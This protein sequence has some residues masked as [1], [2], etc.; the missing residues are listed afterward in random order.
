MLHPN[1][2]KH[3]VA[4]RPFKKKLGSFYISR[5]A[6]SVD[7]GEYG[8]KLTSSI[9]ITARQIESCRVAIMRRIKQYKGA[10]WYNRIFPDTPITQKATGVRM[11]K[12]KGGVDRYEVFAK[13]GTI[14]FE[15][16]G[17]PKDVAESAFEAAKAKLP[18]E[19]R[20]LVR[21]AR[22]SRKIF[23][24]IRGDIKKE[25]NERPKIAGNHKIVTR[26]LYKVN[27]K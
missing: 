21:R 8:L 16:S 20:A 2:T 15:V 1:K 3:R 11:D 27:A 12:G 26:T 4:H 6:N 17:V 7:Y 10:K 9:R 5:T 23:M 18:R 14:I 22:R 13:A 24:R 19:K 25:N